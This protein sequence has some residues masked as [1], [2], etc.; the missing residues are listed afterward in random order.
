M[1]LRSGSPC[2]ILRKRQNK[3][4][5][6]IALA[7]DKKTY[8]PKQRPLSSLIS[9]A[10]YLLYCPRFKG[11]SIGDEFKRD[12]ASRHQVLGLLGGAGAESALECVHFRCY[13]EVG[14]SAAHKLQL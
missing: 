7:I 9:S 6:Y 11:L 13:D 2:L 10:I 4:A 14:R 3:I 5:H 8:P 1:P 12:D